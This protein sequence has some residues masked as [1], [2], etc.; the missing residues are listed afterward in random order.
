MVEVPAPAAPDSVDHV[1][2]AEEIDHASPV[3]FWEQMTGILRRAI[4]SGRLS[5]GK[6]EGG[7]DA[8]ATRYGVSRPTVRRALDVLK[9]EGLVATTRSKGTY[10]L[11]PEDRPKK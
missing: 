10:V 3:P 6:I 4:T 7:E 11:R 8:L 5:P 9:A 2:D 1:P